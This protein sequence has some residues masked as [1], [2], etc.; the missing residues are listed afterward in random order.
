MSDVKTV[1]EITMTSSVTDQVV[2]QLAI[3]PPP[4]QQQ[5]LQFACQLGQ[6]KQKGQPGSNLIKFAGLI[7][8]DDLRLMKKAIEQ[9]C[10]Q[11]DLDEW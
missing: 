11:V 5:V 2:A 9:D 6:A 8:S 1:K 4:L 3:L 10:G 7:P